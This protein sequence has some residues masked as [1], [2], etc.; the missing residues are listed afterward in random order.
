MFVFETLALLGITFFRVLPLSW[1]RKRL[2]QVRK[3]AYKSYVRDRL[4]YDPIL[5]NYQVPF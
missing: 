5:I 3:Y 2:V 4:Y 1:S